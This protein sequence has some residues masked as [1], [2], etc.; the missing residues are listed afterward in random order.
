M[1]ANCSNS[2]RSET[3]LHIVFVFVSVT[4]EVHDGG[5]SGK[6]LAWAASSHAARRRHFLVDRHVVVG[7]RHQPLEQRRDIVG[8]FVAVVF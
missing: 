6:R 7:V 8:Q 4:A 3:G 1:G 2:Y 5:D